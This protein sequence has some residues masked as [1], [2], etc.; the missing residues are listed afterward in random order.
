MAK[1]KAKVKLNEE[2]EYESE[3]ESEISW[4]SGET[5]QEIEE[6][7]IEKDLLTIVEEIC[8]RERFSVN[9]SDFKKRY[10][11]I[12]DNEEDEMT[13]KIR[14]I[15]VRKLANDTDINRIFR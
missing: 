6:D 12:C 3:E 11:S 9:I 4:K 7:I 1:L 2:E 10:I 8:S 15:G 13:K 14:G 5:N